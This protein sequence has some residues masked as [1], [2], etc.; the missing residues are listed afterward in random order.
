[1]ACDSPDAKRVQGRVF[2]EDRSDLKNN[3]YIEDYIGGF[4]RGL[5]L[6]LY[7]GLYGGLL[8]VALNC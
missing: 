1:M 6:G 7:R 5:L 8:L 2:R 3:Y 4:Y